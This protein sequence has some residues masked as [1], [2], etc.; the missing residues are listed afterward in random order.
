VIIHHCVV[1]VADPANG[2][3]TF[4]QGLADAEA[5][6][7]ARV[8]VHAL[9]PSAK[10]GAAVAHFYR[11]DRGWPSAWARSSALKRA[12]EGVTPAADI[13]HTHNLWTDVGA[14]LPRGAAGTRCRLVHSTHGALHPQ[15]LAVG[16]VRKRLV[17]AMSQRATLSRSDLLHAAS[18][19]EASH[20]R[21][22]G[23]GTP[24][25]VVPP[26]VDV[27]SQTEHCAKT[28]HRRV[29]FAGRL[30]RIKAVDRLLVA[31][32]AIAARHSGWE[33][34]ILGPD[35]GVAASLAHLAAGVPR[36]TLAGGVSRQDMSA[37]YGS[38][39]VVVLPSHAENFGMVVAE[40][41]AHG[42]PVVA[43]T[44]TPWSELPSRGCGWWV[45]NDVD[46]L[47]ATLDHAMTL[48]ASTLGAMGRAGRK[49]MSTEFTWPRVAQRMLAA[50]RWISGEGAMPQ[51]IC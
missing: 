11:R 10:L 3:A 20:C 39:D 12:I 22:A 8:E 46:S 15:S 38:C 21:E 34:S 30:H 14:S 19:E 27:P 50:Y 28:G 44:G 16:R 2:V 42:V 33:L 6:A 48:P 35:G 43:S 23:I 41:L 51:D 47:V 29:G 17:W 49:W 37:W 4:V 5:A 45:P 32:K 31:W 9:L 18:K 7:G 36:V 25:V 24:I 1:N 13:L 40:A 26:G